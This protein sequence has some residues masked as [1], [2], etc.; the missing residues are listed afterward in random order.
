MRVK[1]SI[2]LTLCMVFSLTILV[3]G[4][5]E[6]PMLEEQVKQ[7]DL[8]SMEERIPEDPY[9]VEPIEEIGTYGGTLRVATT[10]INGW[11]DHAAVYDFINSF[12]KPSPDADDVV[13]NFAKDIEV[14]DEMDTYTIHLR[15]GVKW[16][17]GHPFTAEDIMFWYEDILQNEDLYPAVGEVFKAN[18][19]LMELTKIDDYTIE[20]NFVAPQPFFLNSLVHQADYLTPKHYLK[21]FH[22]AYVDE[23]ELKKKVEEEGFDHWWE[24][25]EDRN[26]VLM[27]MPQTKE[28]P[29]LTPYKLAKKRSDRLVYERNPYY[30]KVDTEGNQLPYID[31]IDTQLAS[32]SEVVQGKILSGEIDFSSRNVDIRNYPMY[33]KYEEDGEFRTVLW[34]NALGSDVLYQFNMTHEDSGLR[35]VFQNDK[36][37]KAMSLA[38][39]RDEINE[40]IYFGKA[41]PRQFT[42]LPTSK[43]YESEFGEAYAE[44]NPEEAKK[45]LDDA[46]IVDQDGDGWRERPDGED[47]TFTIEFTQRPYPVVPNIEIVTSNWQEIGINV[48]SRQISGELANQRAPGNMMDAA[49]WGGGSVSDIMFPQTIRFFSPVST[50]WSSTVWPKWDQWAASDGEQGEEPPAEIKQI[51]EKWINTLKEPDTDKRISMAKDIVRAQAENLWVIGTVGLSPR[52]V[53]VNEKLRNVPEDNLW[54]WDTL[55]GCHV[56][57][58]QMFYEGGK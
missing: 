33:R 27:N 54:A 53:I 21:D 48:N 42:V 28:R 36:F 11:G 2:L 5:S 39:D 12:V 25:F 31:K 7:G 23:E 10:S 51:H 26:A 6:V 37:R 13:V 1:I 32:D 14:S 49:I 30:W 57:L 18:G 45:L 19:E 52:P 44:Y 50:A 56:D 4:V 3:Q 46:G 9:V 15:E 41:E 34:D 29:A 47:L 43:Y 16:S 24:L 38:I 58:V 8:P 35:E 55:T 40:T 22:P 20:I 17:D